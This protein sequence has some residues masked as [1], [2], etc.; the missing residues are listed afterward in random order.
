MTVPTSGLLP[1]ESTFHC[2]VMGRFWQTLAE[3]TAQ[4]VKENLGLRSYF[5]IIF[6]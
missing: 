3:I 4:K 5:M 2:Q 6:I 1:T